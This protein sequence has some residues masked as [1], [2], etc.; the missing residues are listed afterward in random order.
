MAGY[1][2]VFCPLENRNLVS[3]DVAAAQAAVHH[4]ADALR[5]RRTDILALRIRTVI[6]RLAEAH[7]GIER[8]HSENIEEMRHQFDIT[9]PAR[10]RAVIAAH[11]DAMNTS[12]G[13]RYRLDE[14]RATRG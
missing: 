3:G 8:P 13:D 5:D 7:F 14:N 6:D 1:L 2:V 4:R 12:I 11:R 10:Q 9:R